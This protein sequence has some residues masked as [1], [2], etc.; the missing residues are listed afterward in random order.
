[1]PAEK[2]KSVT[3]VLGPHVGMVEGSFPS[4]HDP[5]LDK[6]DARVAGVRV[7]VDAACSNDLVLH[8][9]ILAGQGKRM[10]ADG[11]V[12]GVLVHMSGE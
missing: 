2:I 8:S 6:R 9:A 10:E 11:R 1:M 4:T 3:L 7:I 5:E 12:D